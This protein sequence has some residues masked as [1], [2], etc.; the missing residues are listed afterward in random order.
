[1]HFLSSVSRQSTRYMLVQFNHFPVNLTVQKIISYILF[2]I[3]KNKFQVQYFRIIYN[4]T[5]S[6]NYGNGVVTLKIASTPSTFVL[7]NMYRVPSN[8]WIKLNHFIF[9][10]QNQ[11]KISNKGSY[12]IAISLLNCSWHPSKEHRIVRIQPRKPVVRQDELWWVFMQF[13]CG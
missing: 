3:L 7:S 2:Q 6:A 8:Y 13:T 12:C 5:I 9:Q 11:H 4:I 10:G 1:M